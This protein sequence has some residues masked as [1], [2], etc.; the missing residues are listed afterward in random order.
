MN[1]DL[2]DQTDLPDNIYRINPAN[3]FNP[4]SPLI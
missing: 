4:G 3:L 1:Q 2:H